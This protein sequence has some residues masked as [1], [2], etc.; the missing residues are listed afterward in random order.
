M[1]PMQL[2]CAIHLY[3]STTIVDSLTNEHC[4]TKMISSDCV[5]VAYCACMCTH[6]SF[7]EYFQMICFTLTRLVAEPR[8][9][10]TTQNWSDLISL[11][12]FNT[13]HFPNIDLFFINVQPV[14]LDAPAS[15]LTGQH[16]SVI[17]TKNTFK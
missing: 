17:K 3:T 14:S 5:C 4:T 11:L 16:I 7:A 15:I 10:T 13:Y 12:E 9:M 1:K 2:V 8:I 6:N